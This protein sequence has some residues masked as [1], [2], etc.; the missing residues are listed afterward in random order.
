MTAARGA[1][2]IG[3][4]G[5][6]HG[7]PSPG[8]ECEHADGGRLRD[9]AQVRVLSDGVPLLRP[10]FDHGFGVAGH[11]E[12][13]RPERGLRAHYRAAQSASQSLTI[14]RTMGS[15]VIVSWPSFSPGYVLQSATNVAGPYENYTG[16][17]VV[18][19]NN[20]AAEVPL[21][22]AQKFF[23]LHKP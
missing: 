1:S 14:Q 19:G 9:G 23:R 22:S 15:T 7:G 20:L 12:P 13:E 17:I 2:F 6:G 18:Q 10:A 4:I 21:D 5:S 8:R 16:N 3:S 11:V